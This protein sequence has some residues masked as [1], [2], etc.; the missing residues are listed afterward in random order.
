M[1][2]RVKIW[3]QGA[4]KP[5]VYRLGVALSIYHKGIRLF[6][7]GRGKKLLIQESLLPSQYT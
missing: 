6:R 3:L 1:L 4:L 5:P 2:E 7:S